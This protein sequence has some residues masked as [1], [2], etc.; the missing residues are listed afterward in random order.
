MG[1]VSPSYNL[2]K[3]VQNVLIKKGYDPGVIDG[4]WGPKTR[5]AIRLFQRDNGL[6]PTH[7]LNNETLTLL[8]SE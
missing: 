7:Y 8:F 6:T 4:L 1:Y 3:K 2:V 5:S